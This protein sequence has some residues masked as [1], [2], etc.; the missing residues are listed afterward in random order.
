MKVR[1]TSIP[2]SSISTFADGGFINPFAH[3]DGGDLFSNPFAYG[4]ELGNVFAGEGDRP[5]TLNLDAANQS[6][7]RRIFGDT[8]FTRFM[9]NTSAALNDPLSYFAGDEI[10]AVIDK[11]GKMS[12]PQLEKFFRTDIGKAIAPYLAGDG[13]YQ[14]QEAG[15]RGAKSVA[16]IVRRV[17]R[18]VQ[19]AAKKAMAQS[20]QIARSQM[21]T[22]K[23]GG[24]PT[25][26]VETT[27]PV[28]RV[29]QSTRGGVNQPGWSTNAGPSTSSTIGSGQAARPLNARVNGT[30][31]RGATPDPYAGLEGSMS[32]GRRTPFE[33]AAERWGGTPAD[34]KEISLLGGASAIGFPFV[35]NY[36]SDMV[37]DALSEESPQ[38][39][40][41]VQPASATSNR[42]NGNKGKAAVTETPA[43][44]PEETGAVSTRRGN[45]DTSRGR[46]NG[47]GTN[48]RNSGSVVPFAYDWYRNGSDGIGTPTGFKV[49]KNG[50]AYDY[51]PEY[52]ALVASLGA[53]DIRKWAAEHPNDPSLKSFLAKGNK[54][55]NLTDEQWRK[56]ATDGK[57]GFMHRVADSMLGGTDEFEEVTEPATTRVAEDPEWAV[58]FGDP[59]VMRNIEAGLNPDGTPISNVGTTRNGFRP[60]QTWT[61][62]LPWMMSG[63]MGLKEMLTPAD[64]GN[65]DAI[66]A[67]AYQAGSPVSI[68]TE[69]IGDYRKRDPFDETYLMNIINQNSRAA[70]RNFMNISGGNR[71][72]AMSGILA[73][74]LVTQR[75]LA[76]A[77]RQAYLANRTDDAQVAE[78]NRGTNI[79]NAQ[80][81]NQRNQFLAQLNS[82]RQNAMLSGISQGARLRQAIKDQRDAA[83]SA[84]LTNFAQGLGDLG[85]EN[86]YYNMIGGLNE[87][88]VLKYFFDD[89]WKTRFNNPQNA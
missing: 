11:L 71:A 50:K 74:D 36:I 72:A 66:T 18:P 79:F 63:I 75:S 20:R 12:E 52:K 45:Q 26:V 51:T 87:E 30:A 46:G 1:I 13:N 10:N 55:E 16:N 88:G 35:A 86:G 31:G 2:K 38:T 15:M 24:R 34:W 89:D 62:N 61:R 82:Q 85:K 40:S 33:A 43:I 6:L 19:I 21:N 8:G 58:D 53:D 47:S 29:T 49:G 3:A 83:I 42:G 69:Y 32:F 37:H 39:S 5:N 22:P 84:N 17:Q 41:A 68:G 67:A 57:Y 27:T 59:E 54:L 65:A 9:E 76:E 73:N 81:Q 28:Q 4:G 7:V 48:A 56:G 80:A 78:F 70:N 14:A 77:A 64:Y 23:G 44:T 60:K 25:R